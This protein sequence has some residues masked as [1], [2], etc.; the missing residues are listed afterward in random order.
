MH[1]IYNRFS[2]LWCETLDVYIKNNMNECVCNKMHWVIANHMY[3][4]N[5]YNLPGLYSKAEWLVYTAK[6]LM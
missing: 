3:Y 6:L 2:A 5:Y 4:H 1:S